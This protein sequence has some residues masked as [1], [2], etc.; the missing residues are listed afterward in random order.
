M[1][2]F[3]LADFRKDLSPKFKLVPKLDRV[4]QDFDEEWDF[5]YEPKQG[6]L[7]WH[8]SG[9]CVPVPSA[10][11][12]LAMNKLHPDPVEDLAFKRKMSKFGPVGHFWHQFLQHIMVRYE[13]VEPSA[14][15]RSAQKGW[16]LAYKDC[17]MDCPGGHSENCMAWANDGYAPFNACV[18]SADVAPWTFKSHDYIVD[19]KTMSSR[20]F[21]RPTLPDDFGK[22]YEC[23]MN[24]YM[25]FFDYDRALIVGI[26]K[27]TPHD[28]KEFEFR[29]NQPLIDVI[30]A[31][32]KF[33]A[34]CIEDEDRPDTDDDKAFELPLEWS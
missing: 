3:T 14:I 28:F 1:P 7:Y 2:S 10:L 24:I 8:P 25:D 16:K 17:T 12:D 15:E 30:Y 32:W 29:R 34:E 6:D 21:Q 5:H 31:K 18:G 33:V 26:N 11:Y 19:F 20:S 27:D 9:N 4:I 22:K 13:M 23:Q